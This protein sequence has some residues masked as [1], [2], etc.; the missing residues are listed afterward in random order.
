MKKLPLT[1]VL[2]C[3]WTRA[4]AQN[5]VPNPGFEKLIACPPGL[6]SIT[7][8]CADW[9]VYTNATTDYFHA[10]TPSNAGIPENYFGYQYAAEGQAYAGL[11]NYQYQ[12]GQDYREYLAADIQP[13]TP[14][15]VYEVSMLVSLANNAGVAAEDLGIYFHKNGPAFVPT[16]YLLQVTP[17][18]SF[19]SAGLILDTANWVRISGKFKA[20]SAYEHMV[21]GGFK[22]PTTVNKVQTWN[23][24]ISKT[25]YY[26]I[27]SVVVNAAD[28]IRFSY[29]GTLCDGDTIMVDYFAQAGIFTPG[30][31][32]QLQLSDANGSFAN[33]ATIGSVTSAASGTI[34]GTIPS[35]TPQGNGYRLRITANSPAFSRVGANTIE[36]YTLPSVSANSNSPVCEQE[37]LHLKP[38]TNVSSAAF[39]WQGPDGFMSSLSEPT[40]TSP[41][42]TGNGKYIVT[43]NNNGCIASDTMDIIVKPL[44]GIQASS[45]SPVCE[46]KQLKLDAAS[47]AGAAIHWQGPAAWS[48]EGNVVLDDVSKINEGIYQATAT[49]E[50]CHS[51]MELNV[52]VDTLPKIALG[53]DKIICPGVVMQIGSAQQGVSYAWNT[54]STEWGLQVNST[55]TYVQTVSNRCGSTT[56]SIMVQVVPCDTCVVMP[57]AFTPNGDGKNDDL[58]PIVR[59]NI[60]EYSFKVIN[61]WGQLLFSTTSPTDKWDG[62]FNNKP[63]ELGTYFYLIRCTPD[64][65]A[66]K[67]V[68]IVMKGDVTIIR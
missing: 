44:P 9:Y 68:D 46:G 37:P 4:F 7:G 17:Q 29:S 62:T 47:V 8:F 63:V 50:G 22:N 28:S 60:K 30:N 56:D 26:Y 27:D 31:I 12:N 23:Y 2:F 48:G 43:V 34:V 45:N 24:S 53:D 33:P 58:S 32:F 52:Q 54:G 66:N 38:N 5:L 6:G 51:T 65:P 36:V 59:C 35:G 49:L 14:G 18:V 1:I 25:S 19:S 61:R 3:L 55:G 41:T 57:S 39:D 67:P 10:C 64:I 40:I 15:V 42:V 13:M 16:Y 11:C 21:I 20:D